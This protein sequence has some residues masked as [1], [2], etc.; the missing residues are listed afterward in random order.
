MLLQYSSPM[1][2]SGGVSGPAPPTQFWQGATDSY[3]TVFQ[4]WPA[5]S[6]PASY[7]V[8]RNGVQVATGVVAAY[9]FAGNGTKQFYLISTG[10][11]ANTTYTFQV[12]SVNGGI[13]GPKS[14]PLSITTLSGTS[15]S[16][17]P[18]APLAVF[19]PAYVTPT[20]IT[21][22]TATN[23]S[24]TNSTGVTGT[25]TL[26]QTGC[27]LQWALS[28]AA[29]G[30]LITVTA[31]STYSTSFG[32]G[33]LVPAAFS[34]S[35]ANGYVYLQTSAYGSLPAAGTRVS[36]SNLSAMAT[37]Q[38]DHATTGGYG[39]S[40]SPGANYLRMVGINVQP[41]PSDTSNFLYYCIYMKASNPGAPVAICSN[42]VIDRCIIGND[43]ANYGTT[44]SPVFHGISVF[45]NN[46]CITESYVYGICDGSVY[47]ASTGDSN[48]IYGSG[49]QYH[50]LNNNYIESGSEGVLY[51]G[52]YIDPNHIPSDITYRNNTNAKLTAWASNPLADQTKN[53]FELKVGNR[54]ACYGNTHFYNLPGG[55][56]SQQGRSFV[57]GARDQQSGSAPLTQCCPWIN[58][59]DVDIYNNVIQNTG[60]AIVIFTAD[61]GT[62]AFTSRVRFKNNQCWLGMPDYYS[63][64]AGQS[65]YP[66]GNCI[67]VSTAVNDL[68]IDHN[69]FVANYTN[70]I[71]FSNSG[72]YVIGLSAWNTNDRMTFTNNIIDGT[73]FFADANGLGYG[74]AS[75]LATRNTNM[76]FNK[77][78]SIF[79]SSFT[80]YPGTNYYASSYAAVGMTT[81][82]NN[83][84]QPNSGDYD[85]APTSAYYTDSTTGGPVGSIL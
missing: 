42:I 2:Q 58:V 69:T 11:L 27:S 15:G 80:G 9:G 66:F 12:T 75:G 19:A 41:Q 5:V 16:T 71:S 48:G 50:T 59:T 24:D 60:P 22:W 14:S 49:G 44:F 52:A 72:L 21:T 83:S 63:V 10:L 51:G 26:G 34:G 82:T 6:N 32:G 28:H 40:L 84:T 31:G 55:I 39:M 43:T 85:L 4:W 7:N 37:I 30:D 77:N 25:G 70:V 79:D 65:F 73:S 78:V 18:A 13:E 38:F 1:Q 29:Y 23:T 57:I 68:I 47:G 3:N 62:T 61:Y 56:G 67:N 36:L 53:H 8:Y 20:P 81:F 17:A 33:F 76:T 46:F 45:C 54:V 35:A 64:N 74:G